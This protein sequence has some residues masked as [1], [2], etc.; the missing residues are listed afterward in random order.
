MYIAQFIHLKVLVFCCLWQVFF[1]VNV[2]AQVGHPD[3]NPG[4]PHFDVDMTGSPD[5]IYISPSTFRERQCCG[6]TNP[7]ICIS[8]SITLDESAVGFL[9]DIH[10]GP[11]P[12]GSL[13]YQIDC[14]EETPVGDPICLGGGQTYY[15]SLCKPGNYENEY[16]IESV[17][18]L[19]LGDSVTAQ[20][21]CEYSLSVSGTNMVEISVVWKDITSYTVEYYRY[22]TYSRECFS[23][24]FTSASNF[25]KFI[26]NE[27]G[28]NVMDLGV[29]FTFL[30]PIS[31]TVMV[32]VVFLPEVSFIP[33]SRFTH[34]L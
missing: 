27:V 6:V 7:D 1:L 8:F 19:I 13:F 4:V 12:S 2:F 15:I 34:F 22:L 29:Q 18:G 21:S 28:V 14:G 17:P 16:R 30:G 5:S 25:P 23:P 31:N 9:F 24:D 20:G 11:E 10:S 32:E 26:E 33:D 3:C